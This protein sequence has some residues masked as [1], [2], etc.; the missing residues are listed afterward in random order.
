M[1]QHLSDVQR[2]IFDHAFP[3]GIAKQ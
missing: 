2:Y 1:H 3:A